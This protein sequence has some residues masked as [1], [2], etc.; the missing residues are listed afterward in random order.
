MGLGDGEDFREFRVNLLCR[1][2]DLDDQYGFH[3]ERITRMGEGLANLNGGL[4]HI[5]HGDRKDTRADDRG[6]AGAPRGGGIKSEKDGP[7][8]FRRADKANRGLSDN[9]KLAFRSCHQTHEVE[10]ASVKLRPAERNDFAIEEHNLETEKIVRRHPVFQAM[11]TAR[12]HA[13]IAADGA[14]NL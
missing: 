6:D 12:I 3:I 7:R 2:L 11:R 13:D 8:P 1:A 10:T 9:P 5:F 4:I 14:S